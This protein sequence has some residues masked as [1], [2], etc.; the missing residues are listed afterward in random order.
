MNEK[1]VEEMDETELKQELK[2]LYKELNELSQEEMEKLEFEA[3]MSMKK[4]N[5]DGE[6]VETREKPI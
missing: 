1:D 2:K 6:V 3:T 5:E 4:K